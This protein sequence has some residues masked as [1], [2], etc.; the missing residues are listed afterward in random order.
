MSSY[1][2][3]K[4]KNCTNYTRGKKII[5]KYNYW[6]TN[7]ETHKIVIILEYLFTFLW[8]FKWLSKIL[9][10]FYNIYYGKKTNNLIKRTISL[11]SFLC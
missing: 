7:I 8:I 2:K 1:Q 3:K 5:I 9:Y 10:Y 6:N 11:E 4:K